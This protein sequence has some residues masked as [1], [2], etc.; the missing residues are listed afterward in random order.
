MDGY[1]RTELKLWLTGKAG[2]ESIG[3]A[4]VYPV[5]DKLR[6]LSTPRSRVVKKPKDHKKHACIVNTYVPC[7]DSFDKEPE[8]R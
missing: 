5:K 6:G 8:I 4:N 2:S 7:C 3:W 1:H